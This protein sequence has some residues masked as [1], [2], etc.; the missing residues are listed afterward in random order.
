[1]TTT[2]RRTLLGLVLCLL[3]VVYLWLAYQS[4]APAIN[5]GDWV[6]FVGTI[7][8]LVPGVGALVAGANLIRTRRA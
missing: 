5:S 2:M 7:I 6:T 4:I 1:M 8:F 3:G